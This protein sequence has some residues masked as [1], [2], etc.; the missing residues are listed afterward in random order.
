MAEVSGVAG[1]RGGEEQR[2]LRWAT[3]RP[4]STEATATEPMLCTLRGPFSS[5]ARTSAR[6]RQ[7]FFSTS[8]ALAMCRRAES[9]DPQFSLYTLAEGRSRG[10]GL[11]EYTKPYMAE[12]AVNLLS[13]HIVDG[14]PL[15][16]DFYEP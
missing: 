16:I 9:R 1:A 14:R 3:T 15:S 7:R 13:G 5:R 11:C 2:C 4:T 8:S 12:K 6:P 10:M